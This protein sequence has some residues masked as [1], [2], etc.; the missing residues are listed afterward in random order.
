[1]QE[2]EEDLEDTR[3]PFGRV[4]APL[5][6]SRTAMVLLSIA[7]IAVIGYLDRLTGTTVSV[8]ALYLIPVVVVAWYI[9]RTGGQMASLAAGGTQI[10]AAT[11][12]SCCFRRR[13]RCRPKSRSA[14]CVER[15]RT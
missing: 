14:T 2:V 15:S 6:R 4:V 11:N 7:T 5:I 8:T 13:A 9:G 1:V 10:A 3:D 12:S